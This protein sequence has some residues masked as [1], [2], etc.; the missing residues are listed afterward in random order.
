MGT[1][2]KAPRGGVDY[3]APTSAEVKDKG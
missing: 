3:P 1:G 2:G